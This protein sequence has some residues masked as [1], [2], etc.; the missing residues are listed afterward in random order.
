[1]MSFIIPSSSSSFS[2]SST[3]AA[4]AISMASV[5]A[6]KATLHQK[7]E[8]RNTTAMTMTSLSGNKS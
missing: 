2:F 3:S 5:A 6:T 1:M 8:E 7:I 4:V